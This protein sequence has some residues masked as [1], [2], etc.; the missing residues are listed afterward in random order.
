MRIGFLYAIMPS[1]MEE[2]KSIIDETLNDKYTRASNKF[3]E[4]Y[5]NRKPSSV[6]HDQVLITCFDGDEQGHIQPNCPSKK[7]QHQQSRKFCNFCKNNVNIIVE[8]RYRRS[9]S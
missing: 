3:I 7:H 5:A 9:H 6:P 1:Y 4:T 8:C 2:A